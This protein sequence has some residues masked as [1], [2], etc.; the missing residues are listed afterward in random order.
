MAVVWVA[1]WN[2]GECAYSQEEYGSFIIVERK[3]YRRKY[4]PIRVFSSTGA[5]KGSG[6][7]DLERILLQFNVCPAN[8]IVVMT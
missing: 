3:I 4:Y 6:L 5:H 1:L 2:V 8:P 7:R